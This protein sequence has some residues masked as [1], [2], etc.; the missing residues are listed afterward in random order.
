MAKAR[1]PRYPAIGLKESVEQVGKIYA[2]DYQNQLPRLVVAQHMGY[3]GLNG[4]ALSAL[5]ALSK[6]GLLE[7][8]G[9]ETKVTD[10]AVRIIA[11]PS[12]TQ[13]RAEALREAASKPDLFAELDAKFQ[14]G[15]ASDQAIRAY[16]LTQKFLPSA[17]D[18]SIRSYRETKTFVEAESDGYTAPEKET[19][20]E[21]APGVTSHIRPRGGFSSAPTAEEIRQAGGH[22][23]PRQ[24]DD[25]FEVT[26]TPSSGLRVVGQLRSLEEVERLIEYLN[27]WKVLLR[28]PDDARR[29]V[30]DAGGSE[31]GN[32]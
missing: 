1:S 11:H 26:A 5:S 9:D 12:G 28:R 14:G 22:V 10:L 7:G 13:E 29:P 15:K 30:P 19:V 2:Q 27:A 21:I 20:V 3:A 16:L 31:T 23:L 4:S 17:A 6:F 25:P 24:G 32:G 18:A 8:R